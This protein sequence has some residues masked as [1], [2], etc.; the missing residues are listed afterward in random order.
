MRMLR[1]RDEARRS[2]RGKQ[3]REAAVHDRF[4]AVRYHG[5]GHPR[6]LHFA[7][8]GAEDFL[9]FYLARKS[10]EIR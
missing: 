7:L 4:T 1:V 3:S 10:Q 5:G 6:C 8:R 2:P 9:E